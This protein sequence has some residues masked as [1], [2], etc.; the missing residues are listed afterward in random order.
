M[1]RIVIFVLI[2]L[3]L[4]LVSACVKSTQQTGQAGNPTALNS[5]SSS[6]SEGN[7]K[8]PSNYRKSDLL[9]MT[10]YNMYYKFALDYPG[11]WITK[12][13]AC[14]TLIDTRNI[15][16]AIDQYS[17]DLHGKYGY[18]LESIKNVDEIFPQMSK[19]FLTVSY[20]EHSSLTNRQITITKN[21]NLKINGYDMVRFEGYMDTPD[22]EVKKVQ[23][24]GYATFFQKYPVYF[25]AVDI[26]PDQSKYQGEM[27]E[28]IDAMAKTFRE[29]E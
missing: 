10:L 28:L 13:A 17:E 11:G 12:R 23:L 5:S 25:V 9:E 27:K 21:E 19:Q 1:K 14:G 29:Y 22:D 3:L 16:F 6:S 4:F 15:Y 18:S 26:T 8:S 24:I 2:G 7:T 20:N